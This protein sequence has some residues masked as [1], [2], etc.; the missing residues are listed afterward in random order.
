MKLAH[1]ML[2]RF[3]GWNTQGDLGPFTFYTAKNMALVFYLRAPPTKPPTPWQ[4]QVREAFAAAAVTWSALPVATKALW[5]LVT[6]RA[7]LRISG[8]N[9]WMYWQ[10]K[11]DRAAIRTIERQTGITLLP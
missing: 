5:E 9:L 4:G 3:L 6:H 8:I 11:Q 10:L 1:Q 2:F 7:H